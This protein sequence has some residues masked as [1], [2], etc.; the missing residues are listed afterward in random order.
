MKTEMK[1]EYGMYNS[2]TRRW[3]VSIVSVGGQAN[4]KEQKSPIAWNGKTPIEQLVQIYGEGEYIK[5]QLLNI[6]NI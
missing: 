3:V 4:V 6:Q 2:Q 5:K 1:V